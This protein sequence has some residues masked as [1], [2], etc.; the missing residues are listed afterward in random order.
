MGFGDNNSASDHLD[1][2]LDHLDM[3]LD[4]LGM[5]H[6]GLR[7]GERQEGLWAQVV[8]GTRG[9]IFPQLFIR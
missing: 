9:I 8:Y 5:D 2:D 6:S 7:H 1:M 3:D 4:H